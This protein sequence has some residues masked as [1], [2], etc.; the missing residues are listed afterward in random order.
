[1][2]FLKKEGL[3]GL[4]YVQLAK[5]IHESE[6]GTAF[7]EAQ[8]IPRCQIHMG[9]LNSLI[10]L[11]RRLATVPMWEII[12]VAPNCGTLPTYRLTTEEIM[13]TKGLSY[14]DKKWAGKFI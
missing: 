4:G 5:K 2:E 6:F 7:K 13:T 8:K 11:K 12:R 1:M 10:K 9:D 3:E 14:L